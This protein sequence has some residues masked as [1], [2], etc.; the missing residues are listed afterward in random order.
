[1]I[2]G[3]SGARSDRNVMSENIFPFGQPV[4]SCAPKVT[5]ARPW[6]VLGAY[7]SALHVRWQ[8]PERFEP[9]A[10]IAAI[11]VDNEPEP[12]WDGADEEAR[13]EQWR[14]DVAF[15]STWGTVSAVGRLNGSSGMWVRDKVMKKFGFE[16]SESWITDCLD[17]YYGSIDG[18]TALQ[19]RFVPFAEATGIA[20]P[21]LAPHPSE[22]EIVRLALSDQRARLDADLKAAQPTNIITLGNAALR[23]FSDFVQQFGTP[24]GKLSPQFG[25]Y[26]KAV[27]ISLNDVSCTW[28]PLAHPAAPKSFQAVHNMLQ[29]KHH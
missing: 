4:L 13:I 6:F 17:T 15:D 14:T 9:A 23:V 3:R 7:P 29:P 21:L 16:R 18:A 10:R 1:M 5:E 27:S 11:P 24:L 20:V 12:F 22:S 25:L 26:G 8:T 19:E 28:Y 2:R